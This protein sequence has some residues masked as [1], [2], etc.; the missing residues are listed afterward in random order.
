MFE[1]VHPLLQ[2][3]AELLPL[4]IRENYLYRFVYMLFTDFGMTCALKVSSLN[5]EHRVMK[6]SK[7]FISI[8]LLALGTVA[9][10]QDSFSDRK[11]AAEFIQVKHS[12]ENIKTTRK[13][14]D[15]LDEFLRHEKDP[16]KEPVVIMSYTMDQADVVYEEV[17]CLESWMTVPFPSGTQEAEIY[18]EPW[19]GMPFNARLLEARQRL[20]SW[21]TIP[22][23]TTESPK[24]ES[25]M[26]TAWL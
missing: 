23:E 21:M 10:S 9:F 5:L 11:M 19:M 12:E 26:T 14:G 8:I 22:F 20:E 1:S 17:Y 4:N 13:V 24:V 15:F 2:F 6:T 3:R 7:F 25:W 16:Y 18:L